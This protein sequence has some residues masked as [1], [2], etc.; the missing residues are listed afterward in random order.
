MK[1][2]PNESTYFGENTFFGQIQKIFGGEPE[3]PTKTKAKRKTESKSKKRERMLRNFEKKY[4]RAQLI[5]LLN[6]LANNESG[7]DIAKDFGVSRERVR[8]WKNVFGEMVTTYRV[9][10]AVV[11]YIK[12]E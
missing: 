12:G 7:E 9:H 1:R 6:A 2:N 4:G 8:Q 10:P 11:R 5:G 3:K